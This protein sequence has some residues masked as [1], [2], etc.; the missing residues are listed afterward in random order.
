MNDY[1]SFYG[2]F[3]AMSHAW[4]TV[5]RPAWIRHR[6]TLIS[7]MGEF[8]IITMSCDER[9]DDRP[10]RKCSTISCVSFSKSKDTCA[11]IHRH[12]YIIYPAVFEL[13]KNSIGGRG[14]RTGGRMEAHTWPGMWCWERTLL[15]P[16]VGAQFF[17]LLARYVPNVAKRSIMRSV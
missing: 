4:L 15:D 2:R 16:T 12:G 6:P 8:I 14:S 9:P 1:G 10:R 17:L 5:Q 7:N 13:F 11:C 3:M